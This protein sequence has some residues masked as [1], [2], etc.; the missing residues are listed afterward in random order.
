LPSEQEARTRFVQEIWP[1]A[2]QLQKSRQ[3]EMKPHLQQLAQRQKV[4]PQANNRLY[5]F[6]EGYS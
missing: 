6:S 3:K 4:H 1:A 5:D 2:L